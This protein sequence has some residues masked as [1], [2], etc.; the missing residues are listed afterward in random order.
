[1]S[2]VDGDIKKDDIDS[3]D[4]PMQDTLVLAESPQSCKFDLAVSPRIFNR[5]AAGDHWVSF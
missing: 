3:S 5:D 2:F 1:M 4:R